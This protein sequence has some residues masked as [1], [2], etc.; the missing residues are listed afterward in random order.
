MPQYV[1]NKTNSG[2]SN[3]DNSKTVNFSIEH[4]IQYIIAANKTDKGY[5][6]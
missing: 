2:W 4:I 5:C 3:E 6:M 1:Q